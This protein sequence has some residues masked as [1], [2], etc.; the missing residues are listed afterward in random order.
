MVGA[1]AGIVACVNISSSG[2]PSG[3]SPPASTA[4]LTA[5]GASGAVPQTPGSAIPAPPQQGVDADIAGLQK[6]LHCAPD[7]TTGPCKVL[8]AMSSCTVW[9]AVSPSGDGRYIGRGWVVQGGVTEEHVTILRSRSVPAGETLGWQ[10]PVKIAISE[11]PKDAGP[12]FAQSSRAVTAFE[13]H[14]VPPAKNAAIDYVKQKTEWLN[15]ARAV[16]TAGSMV[17][18]FSDQPAYLCQGA[19]HELV[20]VQQ[21]FGAQGKSADGLYAQLWPASW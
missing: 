16:R 18:T 19:L 2:A 20:L 14:D 7:A 4:A 5:P 9:S 1:A 13:R 6:L 12:A 11:L 10:L 15:E 3:P 8:T 21:G 17:Q